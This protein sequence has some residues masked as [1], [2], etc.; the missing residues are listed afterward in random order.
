SPDGHTTLLD[1]GL[2]RT[3]DE[4]QNWADRPVAGTLRYLAPELVTSVTAGGPASDLYSL[5]V[6]L[7]ELLAGFPPF[8]AT[9]PA[10]LI[11]LHLQ[12]RATPLASIA[13]Q[14]P[15][16]VVGLVNRLMAKDPM[17]RPA[18]HAE[19]IDELTRLEIACFAA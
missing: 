6:T 10:E 7:Y 12:A 13:P 2:C 17:R 9:E 14:T 15:T 3:A 1:L 19:L 8:D 4:S 18:S 16:P 5:G 11:D